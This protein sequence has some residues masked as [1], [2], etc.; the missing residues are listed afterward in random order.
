[1]QPGNS[2]LDKGDTGFQAN[3][4][5]VIKVSFLWIFTVDIPCGHFTQVD[6]TGL[7]VNDDL[8]RLRNVGWNP[9][10]H[11]QVIC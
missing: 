4:T 3:S 11:H 9:Q 2:L 1:M 6:L 5:V 10:V 7:P 8:Y